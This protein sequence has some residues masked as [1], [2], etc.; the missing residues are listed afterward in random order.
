MTKQKAIERFKNACANQINDERREL[1]VATQWRRN[2]WEVID[3]NG[4]IRI[5]KIKTENKFQSSI[6]VYHTTGFA[7]ANNYCQTKEFSAILTDE[8]YTELEGLYFGDYSQDSHY[9][10]KIGAIIDEQRQTKKFIK[11]FNK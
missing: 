10:K 1:A 11:F 5:E 7:E 2:A 8:E 6:T 3:E 4:L 9:L